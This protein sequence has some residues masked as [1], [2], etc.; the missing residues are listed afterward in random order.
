MSCLLNKPFL[1]CIGIY[2]KEKEFC[3]YGYGCDCANGHKVECRNGL[4]IIAIGWTRGNKKALATIN[5]Q[6]IGK[7]GIMMDDHSNMVT[8]TLSA[9]QIEIL[10]NK[11]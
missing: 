11:P 10:T 6:N 9:E 5:Q 2:I 8:A 1:C 3:N 7:R 4:K